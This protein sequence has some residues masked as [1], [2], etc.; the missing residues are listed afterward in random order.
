V[1]V[2][3]QHLA[4]AQDLL[5]AGASQHATFVIASDCL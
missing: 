1:A 4:I 3:N 5:D 2:Y